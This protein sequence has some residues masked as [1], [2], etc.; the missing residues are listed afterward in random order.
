MVGYDGRH[1]NIAIFMNVAV[2][3]ETVQSTKGWNP[4]QILF[5]AFNGLSDR[6]KNR[7]PGRGVVRSGSA[8]GSVK[9]SSFCSSGPRLT[10]DNC[11]PTLRLPRA[12]QAHSERRLFTGFI[13]AAFKA[14]QLTVNTVMIKERTK[15]NAKIHQDISAR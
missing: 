4:R 7:V 12:R 10:F 15:V 2:I 5:G 6:A 3:K 11:S 8:F 13:I 9:A 1:S 14:C